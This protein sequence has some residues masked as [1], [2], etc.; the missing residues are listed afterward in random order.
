MYPRILKWWL[1][2]ILSFVKGYLKNWYLKK[3]G[4]LYSVVSLLGRQPVYLS[5][6]KILLF[7]FQAW[8]WA[9]LFSCTMQVNRVI[10]LAKAVLLPFSH[11]LFSIISLQNL[12]IWQNKNKTWR[13][14]METQLQIAGAWDIA[15]GNLLSEGV[16]KPDS[17][18]GLYLF[19]FRNSLP[20]FCFDSGKQCL[21][22]GGVG[23]LGPGVFASVLAVEDLSSSS[24]WCGVRTL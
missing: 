9:A 20:D 13:G 1:N 16:G 14:K 3:K 12:V 2:R 22:T 10:S 18:L 11:F 24:R 7:L 6:L 17:F 19:F 15:L 8:L 5:S 23:V 4:K 21:H